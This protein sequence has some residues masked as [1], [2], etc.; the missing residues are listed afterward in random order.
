MV[1]LMLD[2]KPRNTGQNAPQRQMGIHAPEDDVRKY[3]EVRLK[4]DRYC[5]DTS[6]PSKGGREGYDEPLRR[7]S[8]HTKAQENILS[9]SYLAWVYN[10]F[11]S[12][13]LNYTQRIYGTVLT[14]VQG[15]LNKLPAYRSM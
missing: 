6:F 13:E 1:V 5:S 9:Y 7:T 4:I 12:I 14:P 8:S 10:S 11:A 2:A 3:A 15:Q